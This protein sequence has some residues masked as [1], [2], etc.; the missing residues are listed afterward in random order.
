VVEAYDVRPDVK[1][2]VMSLGGK[3]LDL[4]LETGAAQDAGGYA[5]AFDE[6]FYKRQ[7]EL[8]LKAV[9]ANDVVITTAAVPGRKAPTLVTTEMVEAMQPGS[10]IV[11]LAAERG[12]NCELTQPG[13][14]ITHR[15]VMI[16]GPDN[17]PSTVPHDASQMYARNV[18]TL[19]LYLVK[20]GPEGGKLAIDMADE[21]T[22]ETLVTHD[23]KVVH[24]K[25]LGA[26]SEQTKA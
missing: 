9:A 7:R 6:S 10:V 17:L 2:Q 5:R 1:E 21:I 26:L 12:G 11:D 18:S 3:F 20:V 19:L 4:P 15:G 25:V 23:G 24:P 14:T 13:Q 22:R 8:M 16:L